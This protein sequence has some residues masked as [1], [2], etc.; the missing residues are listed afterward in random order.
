MGLTPKKGAGQAMQGDEAGR[1]KRGC[2]VQREQR[3]PG[4]VRLSVAGRRPGL[5]NKRQAN[6]AVEDGVVCGSIDRRANDLRSK[7]RLLT[8]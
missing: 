5:V 1:V 6:R 4:G 3:S 2:R 8:E 7:I